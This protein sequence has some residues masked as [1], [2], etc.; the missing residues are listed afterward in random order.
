MPDLLP[1][2]VAAAL[3]FVQH[4]DNSK[5]EPGGAAS[6]VRQAAYNDALIIIRNFFGF[7]AK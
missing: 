3:A 6:D 7:Y 2:H 4:C 1:V 5:D